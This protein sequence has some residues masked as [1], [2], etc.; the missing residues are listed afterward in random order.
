MKRRIPVVPPLCGYGDF[1]PDRS[2]RGARRYS[3]PDFSF[4]PV[5]LPARAQCAGGVLGTENE[6]PMA[7]QPSPPTGWGQQAPTAQHPA[8]RGPRRGAVWAVVAIA[9][10]VVVAAVVGISVLMGDDES[11]D[12]ETTSVG[13]AAPGASPTSSAPEPGP[14][15]EEPSGAAGTREDPFAAGDAVTA[16]GWSTTIGTTDVDGWAA[17]SADFSDFE[18]T[19]YAP[20]A[21][22]SYVVAPMT[23]VYTDGT[24][25]NLGGFDVTYVGPSG[26][27]YPMTGS[28]CR[29]ALDDLF[30]VS[31]VYEEA[32]VSGTICADVPTADAPD[33]TWRVAVNIYDD[34]SSS[35]SKDYE[36]FVSV[37]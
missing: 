5:A 3:E 32:D 8:P 14:A 18:L 16:G 36:G 7:A 10:A 21:G 26:T 9:V 28:T 22:T 12:D 15:D 24:P 19:E 2:S 17:L 34:A 33:G 4:R 11:T 31:D 23:V 27:E 20:P 35:S 6:V 29:L 25:T 13:E 1:F 30:P 37:D